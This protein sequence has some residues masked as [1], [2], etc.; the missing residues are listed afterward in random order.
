MLEC[1]STTSF[2]EVGAREMIDFNVH[3]VVVVAN[4]EFACGMAVVILPFH[5]C[6]MQSYSPFNPFNKL[7]HAD[8]AME[9]QTVNVRFQWGHVQNLWGAGHICM[10][11][12]VGKS[13]MDPLCA[14]RLTHLH[15]YITYDIIIHAYL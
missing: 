12:H 2:A 15:M 8:C 10:Y 11:Q 13:H 7:P 6:L 4:Y 9:V 14:Y 3:K 5:F 1:Q